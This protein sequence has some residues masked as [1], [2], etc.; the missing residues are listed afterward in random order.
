M[1]QTKEVVLTAETLGL[2]P[3]LSELGYAE[4]DSVIFYRDDEVV[5]ISRGASGDEG[6]PSG[7]GYVGTRPGTGRP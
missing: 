4:G 6:A 2:L 5:A 1:V 7:D 3:E